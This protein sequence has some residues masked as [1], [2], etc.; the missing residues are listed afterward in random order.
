MGAVSDASLALV[1][2]AQLALVTR[3][4]ALQHLSRKQLEH[5]LSTGRLQAVRPGIYKVAGAPDL[6]GQE[7]LSACLAAGP[8]AVASHRSAGE[9]WRLRHMAA[10]VPE[11]TVPAPQWPRLPG[12]VTH[13]TRFLPSG[14]CV[15]RQHIPVTTPARTIVDLS[16]AFEPEVLGRI[17]D[18]ALR[19]RILTLGQ[20][21]AVAE[22]LP[23][24]NRR[25][26]A[27]IA[28][29][30]A[31]RRTG[32]SAGDSDGEVALARLLVAAGLPPPVHQFQ[33]V[34]DGKVYL[35]DLAY[36]EWRIGLEY[37]GWSSHA[38]RSAFD[39]DRARANAFVLAGWTVLYV[40]SAMTDHAVVRW[41]L[42]AR[43]RATHIGKL[44]GFEAVG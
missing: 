41:V 38:T 44:R 40:T 14:Q 20:L 3:F 26:L 2:A 31:D 19:R 35:L 28:G 17:V 37:D 32:F 34:I 24:S 21:A 23:R 11:I 29:V 5:R 9:L 22:L 15:V 43:D 27:T 12:V 36:P 30:L 39:H 7:L 16:S 13:Q 10:A 33:V 42:A 25:S 8:A 1:S 18:D 6:P 4:Q